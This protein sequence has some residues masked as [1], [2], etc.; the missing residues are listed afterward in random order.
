MASSMLNSNLGPTIQLL[1]EH[2]DSKTT[3]TAKHYET[4]AALGTNEVYDKKGNLVSDV[5]QTVR[6]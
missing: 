2:G 4:F 3:A 5:S 1:L 6:A